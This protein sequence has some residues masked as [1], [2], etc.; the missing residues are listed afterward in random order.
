MRQ[1]HG[2]GC[3]YLF[4]LSVRHHGCCA[5]TSS[6]SAAVHHDDAFV[7][8]HEVSGAGKRTEYRRLD[9]SGSCVFEHVG[10][11]LPQRADYDRAELA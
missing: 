8:G 11:A 6:Y 2:W 5:R 3:A 1:N 9:P 7:D 10:N 4:T